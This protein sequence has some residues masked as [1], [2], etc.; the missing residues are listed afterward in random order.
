V[1]RA[2][3]SDKEYKAGRRMDSVFP[4]AGLDKKKPVSQG[5]G[6]MKMMIV[7]QPPE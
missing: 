5:N 1:F 6:L 3:F 4:E 2:A 7:N